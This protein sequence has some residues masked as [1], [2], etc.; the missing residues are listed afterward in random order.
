[1]TTKVVKPDTEWRKVLT[2]QQYKVLRKK[3]TERAGTGEYNKHKAEGAYACAGC[4]QP[5]FNSSEKYDAGCGWPSFWKPADKKHVTEQA[6]RAFGMARTEVL[7]S[8]CDGHL[9]HV[10]EDG[11][12][13]TGQR[14]CINSASLKFV[15]AAP[16]QGSNRESP[17]K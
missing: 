16:D 2:P 4:G 14:Y 9:G 6:D 10:F 5:L 17:D 3:G 1:M 12:A 8:R 7:C 15:P 13:P 11:P